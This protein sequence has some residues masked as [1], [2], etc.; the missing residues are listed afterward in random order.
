[1]SGF[2]QGSNVCT[3]DTERKSIFNE[4]MSIVKELQTKY[5]GKTELA[6]ETDLRLVFIFFMIAMIIIYHKFNKIFN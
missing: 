1:M 2:I 5:G 3:R 4:L 6:T